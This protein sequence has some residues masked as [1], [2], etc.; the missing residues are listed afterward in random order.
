MSGEHDTPIGTPVVIAPGKVFLVGEYAVLDEGCAVL[1]AITR[2]AKAQFTPRMDSMPPMVA[3]LVKRAKTELGEA[4]A[5]LPPGAV[6]VNSDDFHFGCAAGGLGSSAAIAVATVGA[7]YA[8]LGLAIDERKQKIFAL[9]DAGRRAAQG[10][11]GSGADTAAATHGGLIQITRHKDTLPHIDCIAPP[12]GLHL[13]LFSAGRSISTR[14]M[15]A[16]LR[17]YALHKPAA[18]EHAMDN[19]REFAHRFVGEVTAGHSTGAVVA[20]GKYGEE[21]AKLSV[22]ASVPIVTEA[23]ERASHLA[24]EFG[25]IA[26]P[27]G[28]G[29]GEIGLA[30]F[31]TPEA[32]QWFRRACTDP[33]T[34]LEGDLE[35]FGVRCRNPETT[36]DE[37]M[38]VQKALVE[39][40]PEPIVFEHATL[41]GISGIVTAA[42][43]DV[44]TAPE[45]RLNMATVEPVGEPPVRRLR[46]RIIP[47]AAIV[48][49]VAATWYAFPRAT[50]ARGH[51]A[52][53]VPG[54]DEGP[55]SI[56]ATPEMASPPAEGAAAPEKADKL[57]DTKPVQ[58]LPTEPSQSPPAQVHSPGRRSESS[59]HAHRAH[60]G[61]PQSSDADTPSPKPARRAGKLSEEDF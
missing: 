18:F 5:A 36:A 57:A 44:D 50:G 17:E 10:D 30:M 12:A 46:R 7:V 1:A 29:G 32:A 40:S 3:E 4:A 55:G 47:A 31:A 33:L 34:P 9:A 25:G 52:P 22:A 43:E 26:K 60:T 13:V 28:A 61:R 14:Q 20:A 11:V 54:T 8:S 19:L 21:L 39:A 41:L 59:L 35:P 48:L 45:P 16:G 15:T 38:V 49:A 51:D 2:H 42:E 24:H 6:F 58:V 37:S 56:V 23:F 53:N 27:I